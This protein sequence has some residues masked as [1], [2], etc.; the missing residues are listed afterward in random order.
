MYRHGRVVTYET[1]D[2]RVSIVADVP[3]RLAARL[4]PSAEVKSI[5]CE[6]RSLLAVVLASACAPK[7]V[8]LPTVTTPK[9]PEFIEPAI[10]AAVATSPMAAAEAR[11]WRFLQAGDLKTAERELSIALKASPAF[12]PAEAALGYVELA[13]K[14]AKAALPHFDNA[15][16]AR[17]GV[18]VRA[19]RPRPGARWRSTASP[20]RSPRSRPRWRP[21][22]RSTDV[23]GASKS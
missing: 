19:R 12:F 16:A 11:G 3:R 6:G 1:R 5:R 13:R 7:A 23:S 17:A 8:P 15:L 10:P 4:N 20:T 22:R 9:F 14:D 2:G 21:T 18:R